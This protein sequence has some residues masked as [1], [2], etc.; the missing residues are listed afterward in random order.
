M[1]EL[2]VLTEKQ[3]WGKNKLNVL[4]KRGTEA[5]ITD[6]AILLGGKFSNEKHVKNNNSLSGRTGSYWTRREYGYGEKAFDPPSVESDGEKDFPIGTTRY[7]GI[8]PALQFSSIDSIPTNGKEPKRA[9][10][11][12][13][14]V[15]YGY[16]PQ[17][18]APKDMQL[19]LE[20]AYEEGTISRTWD[21]YT[22]DSEPFWDFKENRN[23][24]YEFNGKK[25]VRIKAIS[26]KALREKNIFDLSTFTL[27]NGEQFGSGKD[28]WVE[29]QPV[30]WLVDEETNT[31]L[32]EKIILAG[33]QLYKE[34]TKETIPFYDTEL[35]KFLDKYLS[36]DLNRERERNMKETGINNTENKDK[37]SENSSKAKKEIH[38]SEEAKEVAS[39][40]I[41]FFRKL[42]ERYHA[43]LSKEKE[44]EDTKEK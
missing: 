42:Q 9:K 21:T 15:E 28:V 1:D 5:A 7:I 8:R 10:D 6:F 17:Q 14:E 24:E 19:L 2:T 32:T 35:K 40:A 27:S 26:W 30:K 31:M 34:A 11:G 29:V 43:F 3:C 25:Y 4:K 41:P 33:I 20:K 23:K 16:Y 12:V 18:A 44:K 37:N 13:L 38:S 22:T 39:S 36:K